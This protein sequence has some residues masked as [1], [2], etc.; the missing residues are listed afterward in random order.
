MKTSERNQFSSTVSDVRKGAVND[1]IE[2][3]IGN[4]QKIAATI[5][6]ESENNPGL[7]IGGQTYALVKASSVILVADEK[8]VKFSARHHLSGRCAIH[9]PR[10]G[11]DARNRGMA[12]PAGLYW[13]PYFFKIPCPAGD[14]TNSTKRRPC[15]ESGCAAMP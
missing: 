8:G 15:I 5:T 3:D 11:P 14:S 1:E 2:L 10:T 7:H 4:G 12:M 9:F 13:K 6:R